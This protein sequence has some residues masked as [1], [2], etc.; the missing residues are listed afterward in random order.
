MTETQIQNTKT[1]TIFKTTKN[2]FNLKLINVCL[3]TLIIFSLG[4]YLTSINDLIVKGFEI[5][6]LKTRVNKINDENKNLELKIT[7]MK[8]Y[9]NLSERVG[10]MKMVAV[11]NVSYI[12]VK[13]GAV[14]MK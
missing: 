11:N 5:Q 10:S 4:Y 12:D 14:A 7:L 3:W 9:D 1:K 8:S 2:I 6:D 13:T